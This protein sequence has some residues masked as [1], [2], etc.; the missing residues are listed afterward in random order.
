MDF[1]AFSFISLIY[2]VIGIRIVAQLIQNWRSVWDHNFT[3]T[4]RQIVDQA[5]FFVLIPV[6]VVLHELGHAVA[7][8]SFGKKVVEFGFYGFAGYVAYQPFGLTNTQQMIIAAAGS[9]VNLLLCVIAMAV[10]L[11]WKPPMRA[12]F[13]E[14]LIQFAFISGLNAFVVYPLLDVASGLNGDWRQMYSS[15]VPWLT[16]VIVVVQ[17]AV[18]GAGYW[19]YTNNGM[20]ARQARLT[21]VPAGYERGLLGGIKPAAV[22]PESYSPSER[23]LHE[24]AERVSS[25]WSARVK[26]S[27]QRFPA[28]SAVTLQ[29]NDGPRQLA[30]AARSFKTGI[31][32][33]IQLPMASGPGDSPSP[34][35]MHRWQT[36]PG[37]DELTTALRVAM[38]SAQHS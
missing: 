37:T 1:G 5:A 28:G 3:P 9:F 15:G 26:T 13:N 11:F 30:V 25:G 17:F 27:T 16:G 23:T 8:W 36:L 33:L 20:K 34:R 4:D 38:E 21:D 10:V 35:L 22:A 19:I 24:A 7:V 32:E 14:L 6:S 18:L 29:W 12:A 2:V 31:T